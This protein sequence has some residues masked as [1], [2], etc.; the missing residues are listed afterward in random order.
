ME[1]LECFRKL[2]SLR[3]TTLLSAVDSSL[4]F[5]TVV[6][7]ISTKVDN[8]NFTQPNSNSTI[9]LVT[10]VAACRCKRWAGCFE[11]K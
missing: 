5:H 11:N 4:N 2:N 10:N 7:G 1:A 6:C 3:T 9:Q 8:K